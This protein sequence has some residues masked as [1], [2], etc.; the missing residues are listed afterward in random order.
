[1]RK[2]GMMEAWN[3][4]WETEEGRADWVEPE[5]FV[6]AR[7]PDL[8]AAGVQRVLDL[9]F[10]VGRHAI[11]LAQGGLEVYGIDASE[12]GK[13][14][15]GEW[16]ASAGVELHLTTGDMSKLP[17]ADDFFDAILT[18][19]VIYHGLAAT[20]HQTIG[21]MKRVLRPQGYLICSLISVQNAKARVG[22][23][24][25]HHTYVVPGGGE[26][27]FP[28]HYF[29]REEINSYLQDF[30]ILHCEDVPQHSPTDY[31]WEI[32]ARLK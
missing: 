18:W 13:A 1:M 22:N 30:E 15:A 16:A 2:G 20:I 8:Q 29:D 17:Y 4:A 14:F 26:K 12:N 27:E 11:V 6:M 32:F 10:G 21:E 28:H 24:I 5:T 7:I 19:N 23:E 9:G 25:E 3:Q 31:H